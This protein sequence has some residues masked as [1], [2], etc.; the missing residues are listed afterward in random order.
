MRAATLR[1]FAQAQEW[2]IRG[3]PALLAEHDDHLHL[4]S[5]G[6]LPIATLRQRIAAVAAAHDPA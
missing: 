4:V 3:F 2:G 6:H 1:D 5:N